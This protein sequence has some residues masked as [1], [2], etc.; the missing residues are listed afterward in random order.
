[1]T[2]LQTLQLTADGRS[3]AR[4]NDLRHRIRK[5]SEQAHAA[6][7]GSAERARLRAIGMRL[8]AELKEA[9]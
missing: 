6:Q 7:P 8:I 1:M 4:A 2:H 9:N 3:T 5:L